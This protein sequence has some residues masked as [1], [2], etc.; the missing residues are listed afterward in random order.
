MSML[1]DTGSDGSYGNDL[2]AGL[3]RYHGTDAASEHRKR[4]KQTADLLGALKRIG[5]MDL[6][7]PPDYLGDKYQP[8]YILPQYPPNTMPEDT[9]VAF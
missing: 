8:N 5:I 2:I 7:T 1:R 9:R 3:Q 6:A 4:I